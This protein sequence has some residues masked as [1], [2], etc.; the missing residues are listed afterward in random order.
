[1]I[2]ATHPR[3]VAGLV[4]V[5]LALGAC[6][7]DGIGTDAREPGDPAALPDNEHC[8]P[9]QPAESAPIRASFEDAN[10]VAGG[11][12]FRVYGSGADPVREQVGGEV[13]TIDGES[14]WKLDATFA[15]TV[16]GERR[17]DAWML[18]LGTVDD[19]FVVLCAAGPADVT[20]PPVEE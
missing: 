15:V 6:S 9:P 4:A 5:A 10:L 8:Q 3:A 2:P 11:E 1:M 13:V 18:W 7:A 16:D 19:D 17:V 14:A 20:W 12:M